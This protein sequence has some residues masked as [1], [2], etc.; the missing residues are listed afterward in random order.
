MQRIL[1]FLPLVLFCMLSCNEKETGKKDQQNNAQTSWP[2][3]DSSGADDCVDTL[4]VTM[5]KWSSLN[6]H[7]IIESKDFNENYPMDQNA[8]EFRK[9]VFKLQVDG[10]GE[11]TGIQANT[12]N[13]YLIISGELRLTEGVDTG[14]V[15]RALR[16]PKT[17]EFTSFMVNKF[18]RLFGRDGK[19]LFDRITL[20]PAASRMFPEY[21]TYN[22]DVDG[23]VIGQ[24]N[25]C[26]PARPGFFS[27]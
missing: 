6:Q 16:I 18:F 24:L 25:P 14:S 20:I 8:A 23:K 5:A 7:Y 26:P 19:P 13:E 17:I 10:T 11:V 3:K 27:K 12:L 22:V 21:F 15:S 2:G 4:P 1:L 9:H